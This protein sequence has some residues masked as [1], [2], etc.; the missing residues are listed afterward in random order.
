[1][2]QDLIVFQALSH[3][4]NIICVTYIYI[5]VRSKES[6]HR[7]LH[8]LMHASSIFFLLVSAIRREF[9]DVRTKVKGRKI[10]STLLG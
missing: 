2:V 6:L 8:S 7:V 10:Y 4:Y 9:H 1:M 3:C 5:T